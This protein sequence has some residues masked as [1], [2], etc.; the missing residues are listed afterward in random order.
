MQ[1]FP[2]IIAPLSLSLP[3]IVVFIFAAAPL[4]INEVPT[5]VSN[6]FTSK[7]LREFYQAVLMN[8]VK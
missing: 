2:T 1:V 5:F 3:T 4:L 8:G 6:S 7:L